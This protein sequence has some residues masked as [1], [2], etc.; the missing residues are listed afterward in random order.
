MFEKII[1]AG[2]VLVIYTG[3]LHILGQQPKTVSATET[4]T[5]TEKIEMY[6]STTVLTT[7]ARTN[8]D[9][10][11]KKLV[12]QTLKEVRSLGNGVYYIP[13]IGTDVNIHAASDG[14]KA[15]YELE[16]TEILGA[17]FARFA[18]QD[19]EICSVTGDSSVVTVQGYW[20][21]AYVYS[22][23]KGYWVFTKKKS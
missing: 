18:E 13:S 19:I 17:V 10:E 11:K 7:Q 8:M 23:N 12:E 6:R 5:E 16:N 9:D 1:F 22:T 15:Q 2:A 20:N 21:R 4:R 14:G 3:Y